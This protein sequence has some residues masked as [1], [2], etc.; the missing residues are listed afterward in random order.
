M[1]ITGSLSPL[2]L[3]TCPAEQSGIFTNALCEEEQD[4]SLSATLAYTTAS[5]PP[6]TAGAIEYRF[7][8]ETGVGALD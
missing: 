4:N 5:S 6:K 2:C 7:A 8:F 1:T 3:L